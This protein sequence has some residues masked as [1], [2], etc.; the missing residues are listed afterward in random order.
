MR[1]RRRALTAK[2]CLL[3][4]PATRRPKGAANVST[5]CR[6]KAPGAQGPGALA[7]GRGA[8]PLPPTPRGTRLER[9]QPRPA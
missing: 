9:G 1:H 7:R 5:G 4:Q 2:P 3:A 8:G 6:S